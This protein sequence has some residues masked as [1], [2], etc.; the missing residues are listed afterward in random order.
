M[1]KNEPWPLIKKAKTSTKNAEATKVKARKESNK[2]AKVINKIKGIQYT[3]DIAISTARVLKLFNENK[4]RKFSNQDIAE[5]LG[6]SI[7]TVSSITNRLEA[8][9]DIKIVGNRQTVSAISQ[10]FQHKS[11]AK[12]GFQKEKIDK[13][14]QVIKDTAQVVKELFESNKNSVYTKEDVIKKLQGYSK[15]QIEDSLKILLLNGTIKLLEECKG[16]K[17][18]YQ[19]TSGNK[20]GVEVCTEIDDRYMTVN[21]YLQS[22]NYVGDKEKLRRNLPKHYRMFYSTR[23]LIPEYLKTDLDKCLKKSEK[24]GFFRKVLG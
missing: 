23:G 10:V 22:L 15:G 12:G 1:F 18:L 16:N 8:L 17:A 9:T 19:H 20:K 4:E 3:P 14:K 24:K 6:M 5:E 21:E 13:N 7:G 2:V 11:G